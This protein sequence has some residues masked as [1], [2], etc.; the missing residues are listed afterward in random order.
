[1]VIS[2]QKQSTQMIK[3]FTECIL[4]EETSETKVGT[5]YVYFL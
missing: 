4:K 5:G 2:M 3:G 1:M